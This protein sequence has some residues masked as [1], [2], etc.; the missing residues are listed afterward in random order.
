MDSVFIKTEPESEIDAE[1]K[2][3]LEDPLTGN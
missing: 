3:E 2:E 1:V